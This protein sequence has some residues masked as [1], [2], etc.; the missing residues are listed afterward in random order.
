MA[1]TLLVKVEMT[2]EVWEWVSHANGMGNELVS[3]P[4]GHLPEQDFLPHKVKTKVTPATAP[5][6]VRSV[7]YP[8]VRS[9]HHHKTAML[10]CPA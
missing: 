7:A 10:S 5:K 6:S 8:T 1:E 9:W 4:L 2:S 3:Q